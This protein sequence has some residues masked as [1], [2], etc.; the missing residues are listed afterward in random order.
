MP[1]L[2]ST[3]TVTVLVMTALSLT[4]L[5]PANPYLWVRQPRTSGFS[6]RIESDSRI[7]V[8]SCFGWKALIFLIMETSW[9]G[10]RPFTETR[11]RRIRR[12]VSSS[13]Q[14]RLRMPSRHL[15]TSI[16]PGCSNFRHVLPGDE[17][18][19]GVYIRVH[20]VGHSDR[21]HRGWRT[22]SILRLDIIVS[23]YYR[24]SLTSI[25]D[26]NKE[27]QNGHT[28]HGNVELGG[29][30]NSPP[31]VLLDLPAGGDAHRSTNCGGSVR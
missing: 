25:I 10:A 29:E 23:R 6:S 9:A 13:R 31:I 2:V 27:A 4:A 17:S 7:E 5:W 1:Q 30:W 8:R 11:A 16:H 24:S 22:R 12:S 21:F 26:N 18:V 20:K 28:H 14:E 19:T 15:L 3:T